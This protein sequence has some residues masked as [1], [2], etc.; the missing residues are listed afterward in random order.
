M[1]STAATKAH[2]D[3]IDRRVTALEGDIGSCSCL[4]ASELEEWAA[5]RSSW[6]SHLSDLRRRVEG[7]EQGL[8]VAAAAGA[9]GMAAAESYGGNVLAAID[10]D[11]SQWG[12][13][14]A[15]WQQRVAARGGSLTTPGAAPGLG[16]PWVTIGLVAAVAVGLGAG[17]WY[18][19][20]PARAPRRNPRRLAL[21]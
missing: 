2:L 3:D 1:L 13:E 7:V 12:G 5:W 4:S 10:A 14:L 18:V 15:T 20:G 21:R 8:T 9:I 19:Y 16:V 17:A 11:A 6:R